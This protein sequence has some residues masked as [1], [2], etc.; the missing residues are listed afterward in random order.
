MELII[1]SEKNKS[2]VSDLMEQSI[3]GKSNF[4]KLMRESFLQKLM[5]GI[6]ACYLPNTRKTIVPQSQLYM[7]AYHE[8][9]HAYDFL[10]S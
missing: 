6:N 7:S 1:A 4:K 2:E 9:G 10:K 5:E 8:A 3:K